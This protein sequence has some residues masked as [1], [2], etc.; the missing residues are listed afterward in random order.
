MSQGAIV[1]S[2]IMVA[3]TQ[4]TLYATKLEAAVTDEEAR[5][6]ISGQMSSVVRCYSEM[7]GFFFCFC[8]S[9]TKQAIARLCNQ[10]KPLLC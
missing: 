7:F 1:L 9:S 4:S 10:S 2:Q 8:F 3:L 5:G 6:A